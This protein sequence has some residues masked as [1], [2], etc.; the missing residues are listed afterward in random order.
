[1]GRVHDIISPKEE[2]S[3]S[4]DVLE[5]GQKGNNEYAAPKRDAATALFHSHV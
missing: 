3:N 2:V 4:K 5:E 1:L